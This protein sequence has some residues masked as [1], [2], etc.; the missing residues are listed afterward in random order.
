MVTWGQERPAP[1]A[2][3]PPGGP[4]QAPKVRVS[5]AR[6]KTGP[7]DGIRPMISLV[8][9]WQAPVPGANPAVAS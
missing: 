3:E 5:M 1:A 2:A 4:A 8:R 9:F 6:L 7:A